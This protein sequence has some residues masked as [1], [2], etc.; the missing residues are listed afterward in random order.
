MKL[1]YTL[2]IANTL[3]RYREVNIKKITPYRVECEIHGHP[4]T[5]SGEICTCHGGRLSI[6]IENIGYKRLETYQYPDGIT[7]GD[8]EMMWHIENHMVDAITEIMNFKYVTVKKNRWSEKFEEPSY[9]LTLWSALRT[10]DIEEEIDLLD[11]EVGYEIT[12]GNENIKS[13]IEK[14][15]TIDGGYKYEKK[16]YERKSMGYV[17]NNT[18]EFKEVDGVDIVKIYPYRKGEFKMELKADAA[19]VCEK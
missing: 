6:G 16:R 9:H 4:T 5:I 15:E 13:I 17:A 1:E 11:I 12:Y 14:V 10:L 2:K 7:N 3:A 18:N 8:E 19:E